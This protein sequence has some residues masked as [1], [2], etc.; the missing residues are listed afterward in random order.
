[1]NSSNMLYTTQANFSIP[2]FCIWLYH[3]LFTAVYSSIHPL[4]HSSIHPS[5]YF[6]K[7]ALC[8]FVI[9]PTESWNHLKEDKE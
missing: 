9:M 4:L 5:D 8:I 2:V 6:Y 1:M 7:N 3:S